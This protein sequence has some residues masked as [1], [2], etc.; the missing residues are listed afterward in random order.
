MTTA[1]LAPASRI[2]LDASDGVVVVVL[3]RPERRVAARR[4]RARCA[5]LAGLPLCVGINHG[6]VRLLGAGEGD[7][8]LVG[9]GISVA[10]NVAQ[11]APPAEL[12]V[13]RAFRDALADAAPGLEAHRSCRKGTFTDASLR[14]H[15]LFTRDRGEL[16]RRRRSFAALSAAAAVVLVG[17]GVGGASRST[18]RRH[19]STVMAAKY[20][21]TTVQGEPTCAPWSRR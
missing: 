11:F 15:E 3:R 20:R 13:S 5:P 21:E 19:S 16:A 8:R 18:A 14:T 9:D 12:R 6:A 2:V 7:E 1:E 4:A 17:A 10:A